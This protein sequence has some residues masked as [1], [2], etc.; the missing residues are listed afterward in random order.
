MEVFSIKTPMIRNNINNFIPLNQSPHMGEKNVLAWTPS[1]LLKWSD[2]KAEPN[3]AVFQDSFS[4]IKYH[5]TWVV[6]SEKIGRDIFFTVNKIQLH[7]EFHPILSW[8]RSN[9][10]TEP[11]LKHEQGHFDLAELVKNEYQRTLESVFSDKKFPTRGQNDEQRKQNAKEDSAIMIS[12]E[13]EK[14]EHILQIRRQDY[15]QKTE[16]GQ[17]TKSQLEFDSMF[18]KLRV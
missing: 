4:F 6:D 15:D 8:V 12:N 17:N 9:Y 2:F 5:Y 7:P 3:P 11:L 18:S 13:V 14:I 1:L 16:Y 10:A